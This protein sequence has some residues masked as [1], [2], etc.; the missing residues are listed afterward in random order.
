MLFTSLGFYV[1]L[2]GTLAVFALLPPAF[3]WFW[4]LGAS[5]FFY[6]AS[7][8]GNLAFLAGVTLV[9]L[10]TAWLLKRARTPFVRRASLAFG[11]SVIVGALAAFKYF[12]TAMQSVVGVLAADSSLRAALVGWH[13]PT[14]P[15]GFSF[16]TF[17]AAS[18]L[19][20]VARGR[21]AAPASAGHAAAYL[22]WFPKL[23]AGPID[24]ATNFLP[25][26][27]KPLSP[28]PG[29]FVLGL[30]LIAFGLF[31]KAVI[32]DNLA[33]LVD[34]VYG[35]PAF[36]S[37]VE[38]ALSVYFFAFQIYCDFSGYTDIALGIS[39]LF[40]VRL[41]ENFRRPYL[42]L[43]VRE[44]W[45]ERWHI[46]LSQW[47]RDYLYVPLGGSRTGRGRMYLNLM[48]VFV[49]SGLWHAGLGYGVGW[50]FLAWGALNGAYH[51]IGTAARPLWS[52]LEVSWP[53]A[54][55][56]TGVRLA[57]VL[58]TFHLIAIGW[59]FFR[60]RSVADALLVLKRLATRALDLPGLIWH[61]PFTTDHWL[62]SG[63]IAL[64]IAVE[65]ADE[66][67][68]IFTR[69]ASYPVAVRWAACYLLLA[70]LA[71]LGRWQSRE[72]I[73]MQF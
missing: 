35:I 19:I 28:D 18:Y 67:R 24:R 42:S 61:Y 21:I 69:L 51:C 11:L 39:L 25:Q 52:K 16:Y 58:V 66:N 20:D 41:A 73:Y 14:A 8:P 70:A 33:P 55:N 43:S 63:L 60:A 48:F 57:R 59:V 15:A 4:L 37:P 31:K 47:F 26:I 22:A 32:A 17:A 6:G 65:W 68:S 34:R 56:S 44:F 54:W 62:G 46:S 12:D 72:F 50:T 5:A 40:G 64:L 9:V 30:E 2:A 13:L 7:N 23:L 71:I 36:A 49:V 38:L 1:F 10:F 45:G 29:G 3:R 53:S 27:A